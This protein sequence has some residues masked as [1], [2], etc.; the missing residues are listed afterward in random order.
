MLED[1]CEA[2]GH[3]GKEHSGHIADQIERTVEGPAA[4]TTYQNDL[5][6]VSAAVEPPSDGI[7]CDH[8]VA[9]DGLGEKHVDKVLR[10]R[11]EVSSYMSCAMSTAHETP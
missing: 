7:A 11:K 2:L 3:L 8:R 1:T 10:R 5:E 9:E 4:P 6:E